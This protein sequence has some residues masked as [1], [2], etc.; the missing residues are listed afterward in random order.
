MKDL[1]NLLN[2]VAIATA[3]ETKNSIQ[4]GVLA[5]IR[6]NNSIDFDMALRMMNMACNLKDHNTVV[7]LNSMLDGFYPVGE[8]M[9]EILKEDASQPALLAENEEN[10]FEKM[11]DIIT[12]AFKESVS[13]PNQAAFESLMGRLMPTIPADTEEEIGHSDEIILPIPIDTLELDDLNEKLIEDLKRVENSYQLVEETN[14][15]DFVKAVIRTM[16]LHE[17]YNI[18]DS[19][20]N[21]IVEH[22]CS[23][24]NKN[25]D[26]V[27]S[28][29]EEDMTRMRETLCASYLLHQLH[30][31]DKVIKG[32]KLDKYLEEAIMEVNNTLDCGYSEIIN[33]NEKWAVICNGDKV[34]AT[35]DDYENALISLDDEVEEE[36]QPKE[37]TTTAVTE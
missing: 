23:L 12:G 22:Y 18:G 36:V 27:L 9:D 10:L 5:V 20:I 15:V 29:V 11:R 8:S 1:K 26:V 16:K 32:T 31:D 25:I 2:T 28:S 7:K 24:F 17:L 33:F 6:N 13:K 14:V 21:H 37:I 4:E 3:D 35:A 19:I 34:V 30:A